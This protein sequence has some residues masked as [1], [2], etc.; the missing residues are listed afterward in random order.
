MLKNRRWAPVILLMLLLHPSC[1]TADDRELCDR[2]FEPYP[3]LISSRSTT[4]AH[5]GYVNAMSLYAEGDFEGALDSLKAYLRVPG[6]EKSAHL[7]VAMCLLA[8]GEPE[9][10]EL[11][12]DHLE[13]SNIKGFR[14]QSEWYTLLS[15]VCSGQ[16]QRALPEARRISG[17][18]HTY[19]EQASALARD[20]AAMG[21]T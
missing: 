6:F 14:D 1:G 18:R 10:A 15:W 21:E 13:N 2:Y 17:A 9:Q 3:D 7:Y 4:R 12:I 20:L 8:T 11:H 16:Y 19:R 5:Q